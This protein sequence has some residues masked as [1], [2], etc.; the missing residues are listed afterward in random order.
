[1]ASTIRLMMPNKSKVLRASRS[2]R[3]TV[4]TS[5]GGQLAE[6]PV[7]LVPVRACAGHFL[8]VDVPAV[9]SGGFRGR[10]LNQSFDIF[11]IRLEQVGLR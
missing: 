3:V 8:L 4:T 6:H 9:A 11:P 1:L 5:P 10:T 7:K 2:I